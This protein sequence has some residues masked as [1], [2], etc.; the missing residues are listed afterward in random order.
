VTF[1]PSILH[2]NPLGRDKPWAEGRSRQARMGEKV[3]D[4]I[5][6]H[7]QPGHSMP[8][9][10]IKPIRSPSAKWTTRWFIEEDGG[11]GH[12]NRMTRIDKATSDHSHLSVPYTHG[13]TQIILFLWDGGRRVVNLWIEDLWYESMRI[14]KQLCIIRMPMI[15]CLRDKA[16]FGGGGGDSEGRNIKVLKTERGTPMGDRVKAFWW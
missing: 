3:I 13:H 7:P 6:L 5:H 1:A 8:G 12:R 10:V 11:V 16:Y 15:M 4:T 2:P 9:P 14:P